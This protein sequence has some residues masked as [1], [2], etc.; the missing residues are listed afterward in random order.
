MAAMDGADT[1]ITDTALKT[2]DMLE[3]GTWVALMGTVEA[4]P[5]ATVDTNAES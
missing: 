2:A 5:A 1:I 3:V 4:T